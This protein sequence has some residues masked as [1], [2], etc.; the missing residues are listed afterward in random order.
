MEHRPSSGR[1]APMPATTFNLHARRDERGFTLV[2]L[3]V[4][5]LII[6]ILAAIGIATFANQSTKAHDTDA[7]ASL[8]TAQHTIESLRVDR[9]SYAAI[10]ADDLRAHERA[11]DSARGLDVTTTEDTYTLTVV[12]VSGAAGGGPFHLSRQ[13]ERTERTCDRPDHGACRA[14]GTW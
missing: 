5:L 12:S 2:E 1:I 3:L 11:L 6:A 7:K 10:T 9:G 8:V 4:V 14:G 13:G